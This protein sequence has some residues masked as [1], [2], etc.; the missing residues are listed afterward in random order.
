MMIKTTDPQEELLTQVDEN[1][2]I[3]G[4][5]G[6]KLAHETPGICYRTVYVLVKN[7]KDE[8]LFQKRSPTKDLYPNCWDL[9][10]G[11]HVDWGDSYIDTAAREIN[12][13][14]GIEVKEEELVFRGELKVI[15]PKN[16]E[17]FDVFEY[18]LKSDQQIKLAKDEITDI[19]WMTIKEAK[20]SIK[21]KSLKWYARPEQILGNLY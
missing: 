11:G 3:I 1:N 14:L 6:R 18:T 15:L 16:S 17:F 4:P 5:I 10:V 13:E 2:K 20:D 9:S 21:N 19:K 7:A 8:Y 12:E